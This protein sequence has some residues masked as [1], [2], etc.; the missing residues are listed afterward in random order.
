MDGKEENVLNG[1]F[2]SREK[3]ISYPLNLEIAIG[4]GLRNETPDFQGR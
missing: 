1:A 2:L 3:D 4:F